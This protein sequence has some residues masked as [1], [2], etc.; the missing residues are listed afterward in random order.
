MKKA[1]VTFVFLVAATAMFAQAPIGI[2]QAQINAGFGFSSWGLPV[3]GGVEFG[4][5]ND[6]TVGGE[7]SFRSY[8]DNW[9][10]SDY[11]HTIIGISANGNYHFN[12]LLDIPKEWDVYAGANLGYYIWHTNDSNY[13]GSG[14]SGLGLGA[15]VGGRYYFNDKFGINLEFGGGNAFSGGKVG[16]S[17]R[18]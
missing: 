7:L 16:I 2:G 6:I 8:S 3:Y 5:H 4:V 18:L 9:G 11:R 14:A 12:T 15:Q 1:L 13:K 17:I 10:S